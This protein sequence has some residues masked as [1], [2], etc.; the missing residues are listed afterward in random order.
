MK[1]TDVF[2]NFQIVAQTRLNN[3]RGERQLVVSY[4]PANATGWTTT[5]PWVETG[6][7]ACVHA[8]VFAWHKNLS[9]AVELASALIQIGLMASTIRIDA[10]TAILDGILWAAA[11]EERNEKIVRSGLVRWNGNVIVPVEAIMFSDEAEKIAKSLVKNEIEH[12]KWWWATEPMY[13]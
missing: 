10:T 2:G 13:R 11:V 12:Y 5:T 4:T 1:R 8:I 6:A 9:E 3:G 7:K